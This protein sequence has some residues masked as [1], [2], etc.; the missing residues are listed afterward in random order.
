MVSI[1]QSHGGVFVGANGRHRENQTM[2]IIIPLTVS[3]PKTQGG[4]QPDAAD[5][6]VLMVQVGGGLA[7]TCVFV[8]G[9]VR[10]IIW[11][12]VIDNVDPIKSGLIGHAAPPLAF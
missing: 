3:V 10:L 9:V 11:Y 7:Y 1:T 4:V 5:A 8:R 2:P 12:V 6:A